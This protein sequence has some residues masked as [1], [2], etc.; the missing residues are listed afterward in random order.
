MLFNFVVTFAGRVWFEIWGNEAVSSIQTWLVCRNTNPNNLDSCTEPIRPNAGVLVLE[1]FLTAGQG[2]VLF[3]LFVCQPKTL[4]AWISFFRQR[5]TET[6]SRKTI[7][8]TGAVSKHTHS[9]SGIEMDDRRTSSKHN[10][11]DE[12]SNRDYSTG[13]KKQTEDISMEYA[14]TSDLK[15]STT[16]SVDNP[17]LKSEDQSENTKKVA[18]SDDI[19]GLEKSPS[20]NSPPLKQESEVPPKQE[21]TNDEEDDKEMKIEINKQLFQQENQQQP[22]T[23]NERTNRTESP[24]QIS[25]KVDQHQ[26]EEEE[27]DQ[28]EDQDEDEKPK[29]VEEATNEN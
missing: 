9:K 5:K 20:S 28:V 16:G 24:D 3:L 12:V 22:E 11:T 1:A 8:Q 29:N 23:N 21:T 19:V 7:K 14:S 26:K 15:K 13:S 2:L 6:A 10:R 25:T 4:K 18:F 27:E 17:D